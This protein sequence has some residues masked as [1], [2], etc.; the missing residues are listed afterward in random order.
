MDL[1]LAAIAKHYG[2]SRDDLGDWLFVTCGPSASLFFITLKGRQST[3]GCSREKYSF[4]RGGD[5]K[6]P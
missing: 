1:R 2:F 3:R 6:S 4:R 5:D